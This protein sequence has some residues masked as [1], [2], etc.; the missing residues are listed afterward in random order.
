MKEHYLGLVRDGLKRQKMS[1]ADINTLLK[2]PF[3]GH[4]ARV[5]GVQER[6]RRGDPR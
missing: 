5:D 6:H 1:D 2:K 3:K 4:H